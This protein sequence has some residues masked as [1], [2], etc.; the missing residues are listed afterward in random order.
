MNLDVE[1]ELAKKYPKLFANCANPQSPMTYGIECG[2][3]WANIIRAVCATISNRGYDVVFDQI[4]EK[5]GGLRI[6]WSG[7]QNDAVKAII[8]TAERVAIQ[9]CEM[10]GAPGQT[11]GSNG[12][13][14]T[15][16]NKCFKQS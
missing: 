3:G 9:T 15:I 16:C 14:R 7:P 4:K 10:C 11:H 6:Y 8:E 5:F 13:F 2:D 12:W 1:Q